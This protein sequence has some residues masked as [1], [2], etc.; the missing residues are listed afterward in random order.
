[1]IF[2][3]FKLAT[4]Q[5]LWCNFSLCKTYRAISNASVDVLWQKLVNIAD[6]SWHPLLASTNAPRGLIAKPG[7]IFQVVT[8]L[9]PFPVRLFVERV[10]PG[11]LLSI[12]VLA[13]PGVEQRITYRIESTLCGTYISYSVTLRG[14]LS[15]LLWWWI[16]PYAAEVAAKL[17]QAADQ[18]TRSSHQQRQGGL[19]GCNLDG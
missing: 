6:V 7:L 15:P 14:W 8:R 17:A 18:L 11:E 16:R 1:V 3:S 10:C 13:C 2:Q 5:D 4:V 12:R 19:D 9:T